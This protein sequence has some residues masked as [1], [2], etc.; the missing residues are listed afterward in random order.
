MTCT[1]D[2]LFWGIVAMAVLGF[3]SAVWHVLRGDKQPDAHWAANA[4]QPPGAAPAGFMWV[5]MPTQEAKR[6]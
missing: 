4:P 6:D 3:I 2:T 5:L 1:P